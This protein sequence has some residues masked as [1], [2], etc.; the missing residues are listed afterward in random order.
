MSLIVHAAYD[1]QYVWVGGLLSFNNMF[2]W[3][4]LH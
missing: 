1:M 3:S 4:K 2:N